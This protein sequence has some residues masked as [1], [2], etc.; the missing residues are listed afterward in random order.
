MNR[1]VKITLATTILTVGTFLAFLY[2]HPSAEVDNL[3]LD[4]E[5]RLVV[6]R[7]PRWELPPQ[8]NPVA[9]PSLLDNADL[10]NK[11][12]S[13]ANSPQPGRVADTM[14]PAKKS[15]VLLPIDTGQPPPRLARVFPG[16]DS[17][18]S[19]LLSYALGRREYR[20]EQDVSQLPTTHT[21]A[22]GDTLESLALRYFGDSSRGREIYEANRQILL[23][24][25]V[26]PIGVELVIPTS[27]KSESSVE[28]LM[29]DKPIVPVLR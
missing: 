18:T 28:R 24:P 15:T 27:E 22:D 5:G 23:N 12:T 3:R 9:K 29:P 13:Q 6:L 14:Q 8:A 4:N 20:L 21:I 7:G 10:N 25:S 26:L 11:P 19:P 2:R 16:R 17:A 1:A